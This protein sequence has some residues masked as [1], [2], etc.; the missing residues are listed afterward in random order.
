MQTQFTVLFDACVLYPAPVRDLLLQLASKG[1]F[2]GRWT[3]RIQDE[4]IRNLLKNRSDL[5]ESQLERTRVMMNDSVLDCLVVDYEELISGI[6]LPDPDDVHVLAAAIKSQAQIIVTYNIKDFPIES[7]QKFDI[8]VQ[9]PDTFLRY[10]LDLN[11]PTF[12]SCIK[13]IRARLK[14]PPATANQYLF[15]LFNHLPQTVS[16][17]REYENLI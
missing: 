13:A 6:S 10:Q 12:L 15:T 9:H 14:N 2:R 5:N 3:K 1:L 7:L 16:V 11:L 17:L 8:E 4:W